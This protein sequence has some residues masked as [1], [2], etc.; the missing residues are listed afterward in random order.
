MRMLVSS[1]TH[2]TALGDTEIMIMSDSGI[3]GISTFSARHTYAPQATFSGPVYFGDKYSNRWGNPEPTAFG[4]SL[5]LDTATFGGK[6]I[7][8]AT[9]PFAPKATPQCQLCF[10]A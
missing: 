3:S 6:T 1:I 8:A 9:S 5:K 2:A 4:N 7:T 10:T